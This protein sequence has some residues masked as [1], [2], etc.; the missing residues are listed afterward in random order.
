[1]VHSKYWTQP[2]LKSFTLSSNNDATHKKREM[3]NGAASYITQYGH[4]QLT[5]EL[6]VAAVHSHHNA[7]HLVD[8]VLEVL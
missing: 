8:L 7:G 2:K 5:E 3:H 6:V 1:M 4:C